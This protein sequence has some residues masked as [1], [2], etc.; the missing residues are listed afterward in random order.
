MKAMVYSF[1]GSGNTR[2]LAG[3]L[4]QQLEQLSVHC[5]VH[6]FR[7]TPP[8]PSDCD[9]FGICFPVYCWSPQWMIVQWVR[10]LP[11]MNGKKCFIFENYAGQPA[12]ATRRLWLELKRKNIEV[13]AIGS[14]IALETWTFARSKKN[15]PLLEKAYQETDEKIDLPLFAKRIVDTV[16]GKVKPDSVKPY[17]WSWFDMVVPFFTKPMIGISYGIKIDRSKCTKCGLCVGNCPS[18]AL[19]MPDYP[20]Y[21]KPCAACYGCINICPTDAIDS[22]GTKGKVRYRKVTI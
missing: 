21:K 7:S 12:N 5:T 17:R 14:T 9:F 16:T 2:H 4:V 13:V 20:T 1:S 18:G 22:F 3:K 8:V 10:S 19:T 11:K 6:E 15:M